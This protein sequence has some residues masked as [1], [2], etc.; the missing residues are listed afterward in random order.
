MIGN[1]NAIAKR[2]CNDADIKYCL[3]FGF[4]LVKIRK[5]LVYT[6][7]KSKLLHLLQK[8]GSVMARYLPKVVAMA[9]V[10]AQ[11]G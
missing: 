1:V 11:G 8:N 2:F 10:L 5:V 4:P 6:Y 3:I 7:L 9:F